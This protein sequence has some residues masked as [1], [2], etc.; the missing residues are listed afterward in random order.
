MQKNKTGGVFLR[1]SYSMPILLDVYQI[2]P[3]KEK[4]LSGT[5]DNAPGF[6]GKLNF[7]VD[8]NMLSEQV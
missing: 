1:H 8:Y 2:Q 5:G 7:T 3:D 6:V 4:L